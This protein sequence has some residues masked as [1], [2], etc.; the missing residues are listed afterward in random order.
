MK[1]KEQWQFNSIEGLTRGQAG[2]AFDGVSIVTFVDNRP[3]NKH[4]EPGNAI[5]E[6]ASTF[7]M[8]YKQAADIVTSAVN[9]FKKEQG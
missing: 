5:I 4:K 2:C 1:N 8:S 6:L 3:V 7:N 9:V